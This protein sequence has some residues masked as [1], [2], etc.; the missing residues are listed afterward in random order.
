MDAWRTAAAPLLHE[1]LALQEQHHD[2]EVVRRGATRIAPLHLVDEGCGGFLCWLV[3]VAA[4]DRNGVGRGQELPK[5]GS[6]DDEHI[7]G[8]QPHAPHLWSARGRLGQTAH[9]LPTASRVPEETLEAS[10]R[11]HGAS[12]HRIRGMCLPC[13]ATRRRVAAWLASATGASWIV[14]IVFGD[15]VGC[16]F[17]G[18]EEGDLASASNRVD[19]LQRCSTESMRLRRGRCPHMRTARR[20]DGGGPC[21]SVRRRPRAEAP[22]HSLGVPHPS[23]V[24]QAFSQKRRGQRAAACRRIHILASRDHLA[25]GQETLVEGQTGIA[26]QRRAPQQKTRQLVH[27]EGRHQVAVGAMSVGDG[28]EAP[29]VRQVVHLDA[30]IVVLVVCGNP[31]STLADSADVAPIDQGLDGSARGHGALW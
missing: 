31:T 15:V 28:I 13:A 11:A 7:L 14:Q 4:H 6:Q 16:E 17:H 9:V 2:R 26:V 23:D 8:F 5:P 29:R 24:Q 22:Q 21:C 1:A 10:W 25:H 20:V 3:H 30:R 18:M 12:F 19:R 27:Q